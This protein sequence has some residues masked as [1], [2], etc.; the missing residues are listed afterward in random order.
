MALPLALL[1]SA[2]PSLIKGAF[3]LKNK[4]N[5]DDY[6]NK[7]TETAL[8]RIIANNQ[9]DVVNKTLYNQ[10]TKGAKS[11]GSRLY[12]QQE[13]GLDVAKEKGLLTEGQY[14]RALLQG[15]TDIQSQVGQQ[16]QGALVE[17]TKYTAGLQD[18]VDKATIQLGAM[19]DQARREYLAAKYQHK[20]ELWGVGMD[21]AATGVNVFNQVMS[22]DSNK[23]FMTDL[24]NRFGKP[25]EWIG[26]VDKMNTILS[27]MLL[28]NA[29]F[30]MLG[31]MGGQSITGEV[32]KFLSNPEMVADK[33][34]RYL[35]PTNPNALS[36]LYQ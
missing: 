17:N 36:Y 14:A 29:G 26:N 3:L 11:L 35:D 23:R 4:P 30:D 31:G 27:I 24:T 12:Q 1:A 9:A 25:E 10:L 5:E 6:R 22:D 7:N 28:K 13:H 32:D 15:G 2:V 8:G 33:S 20:A 18:N 19:K 34:Q 21:L 16:E